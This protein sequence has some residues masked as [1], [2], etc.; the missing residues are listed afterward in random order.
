MGYRLLHTVS[1]IS[2]LILA[3]LATGY[4]KQVSLAAEGVAPVANQVYLPLIQGSSPQVVETPTAPPTET[5]TETPTATP[6]KPD[7][8]PGTIRL[9]RFVE[10]T[11]KTSNANVLVDAAGGS[12]V[13]FYY[14]ESTFDERPT[15]AV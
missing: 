10:Q 8:P 7:T 15:G 4:V 3:I 11:L 2:A 13:A 5:P 6:T 9:T 12:H 1:V 14:Y